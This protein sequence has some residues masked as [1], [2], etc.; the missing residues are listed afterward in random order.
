M[1]TGAGLTCTSTSLTVGDSIK[2]QANPLTFSISDG[3]TTYTVSVYFYVVR[4]IRCNQ[5]LVNPLSIPYTNGGQYYLGCA[6]EL[7]GTTA[8]YL[9]ATYTGCV[10]SNNVAFTGLSNGGFA[11]AASATL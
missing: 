4:S 2:N 10:D 9:T 7:G 11:A 3:T 6:L 1:C 8:P 5:S